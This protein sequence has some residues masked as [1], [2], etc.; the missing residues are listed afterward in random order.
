LSCKGC[1]SVT[2]LLT[3]GGQQNCC[4]SALKCDQQ[5]LQ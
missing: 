4:W 1:C 5:E 3:H 2:G